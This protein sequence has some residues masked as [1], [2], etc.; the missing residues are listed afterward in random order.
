MSWMPQD[1]G[2]LLEYSDAH[3]LYP[4]LSYILLV[5]FLVNAVNARVA[6]CLNE[7]CLSTWLTKPTKVLN[8]LSY[9]ANNEL[10]HTP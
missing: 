2:S 3:R 9:R 1:T 5:T 8:L 6:F 4:S 10:D 7:S